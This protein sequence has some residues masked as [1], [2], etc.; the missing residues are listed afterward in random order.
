MKNLNTRLPDEVHAALKTMAEQ[1]HRSLNA[2]V[3]VLIEEEEQRR[4][5]VR[6]GAWR[7]D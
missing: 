2:M 4:K 5:A 1:D 3:I 7:E 6:L